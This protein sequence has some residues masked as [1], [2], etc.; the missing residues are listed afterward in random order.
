M[1]ERIIY[2]ISDNHINKSSFDSPKWEFTRKNLLNVFETIKKDLK[3]KNK[4][5]LVFGWDTFDKFEATND[6][7]KWEYWL[8]SILTSYFMGTNLKIIMIVWNHDC[9]N[10]SEFTALS[11]FNKYNSDF[12]WI[13]F[14][15]SE[16]ELENKEIEGINFTLAPFP[17][18]HK[19]RKKWEYL[20]ILNNQENK[21]ILLSHFIVD[22]TPAS[23]HEGFSYRN[24]HSTHN[25]LA[26][27]GYKYILL[28]DNHTP[29]KMENIISIW[30]SEQH[31]FSEE[32]EEKSIVKINFDKDEFSRIKI[33][34]ASTKKQTL[35]FIFKEDKT[36]EEI[37]SNE[38]SWKDLKEKD[39]RV[40]LSVP[41]NLQNEIG[42]IRKLLHS[43]KKEAISYK[44]E[45]EISE[46]TELKK[47]DEIWTQELLNEDSLV[48]EYSKKIFNT[49]DEKFHLEILKRKDIIL[50]KKDFVLEEIFERMNK[51]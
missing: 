18:L 39:I 35:N 6:F 23:N 27:I 17:F 43:I 9:N 31:S 49:S 7:K 36:I 13:E 45:I 16:T 19:H 40:R 2:A 25:E 21:Q 37:I 5:I 46:K 10:V 20:E 11:G 4:N 3:K 28:W 50:N 12:S 42:N 38:I 14:I 51:L 41:Y 30:S 47:L 15:L 34:E 29:Y 44:E 33:E 1:S 48:S 32:W 26:N 8:A 22:W 24:V